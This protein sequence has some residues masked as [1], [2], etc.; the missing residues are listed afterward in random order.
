MNI[1]KI[2]A[3]KI[4]SY[5]ALK[6]LSFCLDVYMQDSFVFNKA[7]MEVI[8]DSFFLSPQQSKMAMKYLVSI[9]LITKL[10]RGKYKVS[11]ETVRIT[12]N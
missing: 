7:T 11:D 6:L 10:S 8:E 2:A 3:N 12:T 9:G 5:P 1:T 4:K